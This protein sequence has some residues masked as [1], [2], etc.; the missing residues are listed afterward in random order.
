M[1]TRKEFVL[2]K[3]TKM[4]EF[5]ATHFEGKSFLPPLG[6]I[7]LVDVIMIMTHSFAKDFRNH[8]K[9]IETIPLLTS[10][11]GVSISKEKLELHK[12]EIGNHIDEFVEFLK[13]QK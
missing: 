8:D 13:N 4:Q 6:D 10:A 12:N 11:Y 3:Y 9:Y 2:E 5:C 1:K 7:D